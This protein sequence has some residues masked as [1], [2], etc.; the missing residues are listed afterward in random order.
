MSGTILSCQE[1]PLKWPSNVALDQVTT[2][3][4]C[5]IRVF[6]NGPG[7]L[8]I[9]TRRQN[10]G[11]GDGVNIVE[12]TG[13]GADYRGQQY[14]Y[15]ESIFHAPGLHVFPGQSTPY[16]AEYHIHMRTAPNVSPARSL[17]IVIPASY[18]VEG[19]GGDYYAAMSR[20]ISDVRPSIASLL[21]IGSDILQYQG[22]DIRGRT[23]ANLTPDTC[24]SD[25]ERQFL[26][27]LTV[28]HIDA[29]HI[30]RIYTEGSLSTDL[31]DWPA[32]GA[33]PT[34]SIPTD[35]LLT[36][37]ILAKPGILGKPSAKAQKDKKKATSELECKPLT[38]V[39]GKT[40]VD[41]SGKT[42]LLGD[43]YTKDGEGQGQEQSK[44]KAIP[45]WAKT[46]MVTLVFFLSILFW[47]WVI[48]ALLWNTIFQA[49]STNLPK[50]TTIKILV[51]LLLTIIF[52][53]VYESIQRSLGLL[54]L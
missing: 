32:P 44:G 22:P 18:M 38:I 10:N 7:P 28:S 16:P 45:Y 49:S 48:T 54:R 42:I 34:Q 51:I 36:K 53:F 9:L 52:A 6:S 43:L 39:D 20:T 35:R 14:V 50:W 23:K 5:G 29:V 8:Q 24:S 11:L 21:P 13:L 17:T 19:L 15:E 31:R 1:T 33:Y 12:D 4:T 46:V 47:D 27:V 41:V 37:A 40:A 30:N 25:N 2:C 26:L 3:S